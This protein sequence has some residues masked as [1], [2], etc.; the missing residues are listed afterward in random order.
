[1]RM[2]K[3]IKG[4]VKNKRRNKNDRRNKRHCENKRRNDL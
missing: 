4:T 2:A 1:M 3:V